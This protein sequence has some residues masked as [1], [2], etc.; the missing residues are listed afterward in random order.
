[1]QSSTAF[2]KIKTL[3]AEDDK[4]ISLIYEIG[5]NEEVFEKRFLT[6]G[7]DVLE[8][9]EEW[10]PDILILDIMLPGTSGYAIL[11]VIREEKESTGTAIIMATS[12]SDRAAVMDCL[13]LGIQG[14]MVKPFTHKEIS[15]RVLSYYQKT[16][17]KRAAS[18]L[19]LLDS[20][21]AEAVKSD[22]EKNTE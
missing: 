12:L 20:I 9:Y 22:K 2:E 21:K 1:M 17:P 18:A 8:A 16:N 7:D 6:N 15:L 4:S 5:L 11:K 10:K 14:Y 13:E 19:A 3:I